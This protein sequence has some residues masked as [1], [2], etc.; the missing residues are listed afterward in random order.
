MVVP[1][2]GC[3]LTRYSSAGSGPKPSMHLLPGATAAGFGWRGPPRPPATGSN[4]SSISTKRY[5]TRSG[6]F[7]GGCKRHIAGQ[8]TSKRMGRKRVCTS[9][10]THTPRESETRRVSLV[11]CVGERRSLAI[12]I[13]DQWLLGVT[14]SAECGCS[15][16]RSGRASS[17]RASRRPTC[18]QGLFETGHCVQA[19]LNQAWREITRQLNNNL[20][21]FSMR[22]VVPVVPQ[23]GRLQSLVKSCTA[24]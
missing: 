18:D 13:A 8:E 22:L 14:P 4:G 9:G 15:R 19:D 2:R 6:K 12:A 20:T 16:V 1:D 5:D 11:A 24:Q 17:S 7:L 21:A 3:V 10:N 23:A